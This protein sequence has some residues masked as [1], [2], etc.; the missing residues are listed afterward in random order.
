[1][2]FTI[3]LWRLCSSSD[4]YTGLHLQQWRQAYTDGQYY[5][6]ST[7]CDGGNTSGP[8]GRGRCTCVNGDDKYNSTANGKGGGERGTVLC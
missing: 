5:D 4:H 6:G 7:G 1:M 3:N 2:T 8:G